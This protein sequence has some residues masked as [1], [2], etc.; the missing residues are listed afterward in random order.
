MVVETA[1]FASLLAR[2]FHP[3][4]ALWGFVLHEPVEA[5]ETALY[6]LRVLALFCLRSLADALRALDQML[7][8]CTTPM[9]RYIMKNIIDYHVWLKTK[10]DEW[11]THELAEF[12][13]FLEDRGRVQAKK[14]VLQQCLCSLLEKYH[15][16]PRSSWWKKVKMIQ[17][18]QSLQRLLLLLQGCTTTQHVKRCLRLFFRNYSE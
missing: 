14:E 13:R 12:I 5:R 6:A 9:R 2:V 15:F 17:N 11:M 3:D 18:D 16:S 7:W 10:E 1:A 4:E 8:L